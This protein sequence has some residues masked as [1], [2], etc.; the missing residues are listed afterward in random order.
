MLFVI[1]QDDDKDKESNGVCGCSRHY[2]EKRNDVGELCTLVRARIV[3]LGPRLFSEYVRISQAQFAHFIISILNVTTSRQTMIKCRQSQYI[4]LTYIY[5]AYEA[6]GLHR[7][8]RQRN[9]NNQL[10]KT[11]ALI[12]QEHVW[13]AVSRRKIAPEAIE[14]GTARVSRRNK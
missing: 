5:R 2:T 14:R 12:G 7:P 11:K 6:T 4:L 8:A 10:I 1:L 3:P 9:V 13:R